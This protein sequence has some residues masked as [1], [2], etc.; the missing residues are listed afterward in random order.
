MNPDGKP[1]RR[2]TRRQQLFVE[3]Y[4]ALGIGTQAAIRAGYSAHTAQP[5]A[6]TLL[7][8]PHVAA[9]IRAGQQA[10]AA[11]AAVTA[12]R[13][14]AELA[15]LAFS[16]VTAI[17]DWG[18]DGMALHP[19]A[20]TSPDDSAAIADLSVRKTR[21]AVRTHVR[22]HAKQGALDALAKYLGLYGHSAK[23]DASAAPPILSAA[24][25]ALLYRKLGLP[26]P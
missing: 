2:L 11:R 13:V 24:A 26:D 5:I 16:D 7:T 18:P 14:I 6:S 21:W 1:L 17:A 20:E 19:L 8:K 22:L 3:A 15:R 12:E 9:A 4:L 23:L 25:R 10:Q